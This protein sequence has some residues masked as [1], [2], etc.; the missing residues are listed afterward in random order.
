MGKSDTLKIG[1]Q[2]NQNIVNKEQ[3]RHDRHKKLT[4][5]QTNENY[6]IDIIDIKTVFITPN[7]R[8]IAEDIIAYI[9]VNLAEKTKGKD[10]IDVIK[11]QF[12][13][14]LTQDDFNGQK[15]IDNKSLEEEK[16]QSEYQNKGMNVVVND[17]LLMGHTNFKQTNAK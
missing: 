15:S 3:Q 17:D 12:V 1:F 14:F 10:Y 16:S 2:L 9:Q 4:K 7:A 8:V 5:S 6:Q 11:P 13:D